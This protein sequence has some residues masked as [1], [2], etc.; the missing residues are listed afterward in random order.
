MIEKELIKV[1]DTCLFLTTETPS[2]EEAKKVIVLHLSV[3]EGD[4]IQLKFIESGNTVL[5]NPYSSIFIGLK[6]E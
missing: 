6:K 2:S 4:T 1:G 3:G 5:I